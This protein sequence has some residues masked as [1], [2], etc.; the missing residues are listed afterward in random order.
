MFKVFTQHL[1]YKIGLLVILFSFF[2]TAIIFYTVDYYY[3]DT[4][5]LLDAHELYFYGNIIGDWNLSSNLEKVKK[6]INNLRWIVSIYNPD[7]SLYWYYPEE[8]NPQGYLNYIDSKDMENL[9]GVK[10]P[11]Y[12][13]LGSTE[14]RDYVT[15]VKKDSLHVFIVADQ[16]F[17]PDYI[18]YLPPMAVSLI[19][20]VVFYLFIKRFFRPIKWINQRIR[21]LRDG[22]M[23]SKIKVVS[24]DELSDLSLSINKMID[25][26]KTLLSQKQRLLLDVSHELRSPLARMRLLIE[27]I[28]EHKNKHKMIDEVVFLEGMISNLL[29]SDKLSVPYSNIDKSIFTINNLL[30]TVLDLINVDLD[31]FDI[32]KETSN[33]QINGDKTKLIIAL[34]NLLD[35]AIKYGDENEKIKIIISKNKNYWTVCIANRGHNLNSKEL[36]EIFTP[37]YRSERIKNNTSGFG[38]GLTIAKK[39]A[40]GHGGNLFVSTKNHYVQFS[41]EIPTETK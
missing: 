11:L 18:N 8:F 6:E 26:I 35:N 39:A 31:K 34:R 12:V 20:M 4:D 32:I 30:N 38:L 17:A 10:S 22:D 36:K 7:S 25:D 15:Y 40:E 2:L 3:E 21:A 5:T 37:F 41:I 27:M 16:E 14:L 23:E 1:F 28:P 24:N 29:F 9:H 19:F 33:F 13:S